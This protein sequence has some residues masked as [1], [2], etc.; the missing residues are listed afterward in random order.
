MY[1]QP[2]VTFVCLW[3][4][5]HATSGGMWHTENRLHWTGLFFLLH[6]FVCGSPAFWCKWFGWHHIFLQHASTFSSWC[7]CDFYYWVFSYSVLLCL[8]LQCFSDLYKIPVFNPITQVSWRREIT[9]V[10]TWVSWGKICSIVLSW[11]EISYCIHKIMGN[12]LSSLYSKK[13]AA[14]TNAHSNDDHQSIS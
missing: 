4:S 13:L 6:A 12:E 3:D 14:T 5:L 7:S 1:K 2:E 8:F 11:R 9:N 10:Y